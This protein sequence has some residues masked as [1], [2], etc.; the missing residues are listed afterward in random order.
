MK[1]DHCPK[2]KRGTVLE[3]RVGWY[4]SRRYDKR[5]PCDWE[6]GDVSKPT[7]RKRKGKT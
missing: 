3:W 2:C 6:A 5:K 7:G 4:C 1:A